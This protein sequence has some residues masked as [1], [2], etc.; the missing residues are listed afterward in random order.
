MSEIER[1]PNFQNDPI[2]IARSQG[3]GRYLVSFVGVDEVKITNKEDLKNFKKF[4]RSYNQDDF[5][6]LDQFISSS[7]DDDIDSD[8]E[9]YNTA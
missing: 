3:K 1:Y 9:I 6:L 8:E 7:E 2:E 4:S 5:E